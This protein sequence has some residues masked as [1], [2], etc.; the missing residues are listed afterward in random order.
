MGAS[1]GLIQG[2]IPPSD[3]VIMSD[4]NVHNSSWLKNSNKWDTRQNGENFSI[5]YDLLQLVYFPARVPDIS[6]RSANI[7]GLLLT[8]NEDG[9]RISSS[10]PLEMS[11]ISWY[12]PLAFTR[13]IHKK[14]V[15]RNLEPY[16]TIDLQT[17][18]LKYG[19]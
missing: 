15:P 11:I 6:G 5:I 18:R 7:L 4:F 17:G 14:N 8:N 12:Q 16:G 19:S 2:Q 9:F 3:I 13:L 1:V 10:R